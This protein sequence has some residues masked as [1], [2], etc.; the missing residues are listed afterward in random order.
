MDMFFQ[1]LAEWLGDLSER[2]YG[3]LAGCLAVLAVTGLFVAGLWLAW[4]LL[5]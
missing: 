3:R 2:R 4:R 1:G 5:T